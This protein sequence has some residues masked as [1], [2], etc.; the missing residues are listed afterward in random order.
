MLA[1]E[2]DIQSVL[3]ELIETYGFCSV[4]NQLVDMVNGE[5]RL[6]IESKTLSFDTDIYNFF[7]TKKVD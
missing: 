4:A 2:K 6:K 3:N 7:I 1:F 5:S